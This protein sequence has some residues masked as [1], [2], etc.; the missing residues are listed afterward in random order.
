MRPDEK[1]ILGFIYQSFDL[2]GT[3]V[4]AVSGALAATKHRLDLFGVL[5]L[6][7]AAATFG[8]IAR[9]LLIGAVPPASIQDGRYLFVSMLAGTVTFYFHGVVSRLRNAILL[10]DAAG[11]GLF[12]VTGAA[13]ALVYHLDPVPAALLGMLTG[14][15]GGVV[16]DVLVSEIPVVFRK[17]VYAVAALLG[18]SIM[19]AGT[20]ARLP[21]GPVA[22]IGAALC[23]LVRLLAIRRGW[24]FPVPN[25]PEAPPK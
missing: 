19:V 3:F 23:F 24:Q 21:A 14:I 9:D 15:G 1:I 10:Y 20:M 13:K 12:A 22:A 17:D 11:L 4:F 8:G 25:L 16:R 6:S 2:G 5:V 18:A 7:F